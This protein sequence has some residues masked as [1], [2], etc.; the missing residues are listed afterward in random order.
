MLKD[1]T[2]KGG[3]GNPSPTKNAIHSSDSA[4]LS[5]IGNVAKAAVQSSCTS[6]HN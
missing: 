6:Y 5:F 4:E 3:T 2:F 1:S